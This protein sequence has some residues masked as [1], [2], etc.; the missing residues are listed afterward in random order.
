MA[1]QRA[2]EAGC[3]E[4]VYYRAGGRVTEGAHSNVH[5]L[6]DGVLITAPLDNLILPGIARA[7]LL[8]ACAALGV[9]VREEPYSLEAL[10][11]ADEVLVTSSSN[12][13]LHACEIDGRAV[14][15]KAPELFEKLRSWIIDEYYDATK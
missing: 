1:S 7:H 12:L 15:C 4:S 10:F 14:G 5:I 2:K 3:H 11:D 13:I 9:A 6:R 8:R